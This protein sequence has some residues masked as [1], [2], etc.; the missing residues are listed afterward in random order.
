MIAVTDS[1]V[2]VC[3]VVCTFATCHYSVCPDGSI[4][5]FVM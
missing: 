4:P 5:S 1:T 3:V 2:C